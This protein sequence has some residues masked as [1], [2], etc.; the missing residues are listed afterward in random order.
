MSISYVGLKEVGW[1]GLADDRD[2]QRSLCRKR[3]ATKLPVSLLFILLNQSVLTTGSSHFTASKRVL[4]LRKGKKPFDENYI[5]Y[6]RILLQ[7]RNYDKCFGELHRTLKHSY[8]MG[9]RK[10]TSLKKQIHLRSIHAKANTVECATGFRNW[11][12][13]AIY[14]ETDLEI[15]VSVDTLPIS[16][17]IY[18]LLSH[19]PLAHLQVLCVWKA[20]SSSSRKIIQKYLSL[21]KGP[22]Y[23]LPQ[24][25]LTG[26]NAH[27]G[28]G[29]W[30]LQKC[31]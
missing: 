3:K 5:Y 24:C 13:E 25:P 17:Q 23:C 18:D 21:Q 19:H 11:G 26:A 14:E 27:A 1:E 28:P 15:W 2:C 12:H 4:T 29:P 8:L 30:G 7:L 16:V 9:K 31:F 22:R 6:W 10:M 20:H